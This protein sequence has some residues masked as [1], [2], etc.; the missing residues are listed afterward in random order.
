MTRYIK[1]F[2]ALFFILLMSQKSRAQYPL[3]SSPILETEDLM[4]KLYSSQL[5]ELCFL[6]GQ[7]YLQNLDENSPVH[8]KHEVMYYTVQSAIASNRRGMLEWVDVALSDASLPNHYYDRICF[9]MGE[10]YFDQQSYAKS[11]AYFT[12]SGIDN[13]SEEELLEKK[14][15]LGY[16]AFLQKNFD[17]ALV[18]FGSLKDLPSPYIY[19]ANYYY[20]LVNFGKGNYD[21]ALHSF[22]YIDNHPK[23]SNVIKYYVAEVYYYENRLRDC[24]DYAIDALNDDSTVYK[25]NLHALLAQSYFELEEYPR[26][27]KQFHEAE[28]AGYELSTTQVY[29]LAYAFYQ[30]NN[31]DS[32]IKNFKTLSEMQDSVG[33]NAMYLLADCYL[34]KNDIQSAKYAFNYCKDLPFNPTI[35]ENSHFNYIKSCFALGEYHEALRS[36]EK[37]DEMYPNTKYEKEKDQMAANIFLNTNNFEKGWELLAKD[38][39]SE[40]RLTQKLL[41]KLA[42]QNAK[43]N[44]NVNKNEYALKYLEYSN[45]HRVDNAVSIETD[46]WLGECYT[47]LGEYEKSTRYSKRY[48]MNSGSHS[49]G[50]P[51]RSIA[52]YNLAYNYLWMDKP[53]STI[54]WA[55]KNY[56]SKYVDAQMN[57]LSATRIAD[58][59][60]MK[61]DYVSAVNWYQKSEANNPNPAYI[62]FQKSKIAG[63]SHNASTQFELLKSLAEDPNNPYQHKSTFELA[64]AYYT[65]QKYSH[66][67]RWYDKSIS[68][69]YKA[70]TSLY[71]KG[72]C[73]EHL[74]NDQQALIAYGEVLDD[75]PQSDEASL[76]LSQAKQI[77]INNNQIEE[78]REFVQLHGQTGI[79]DSDLDSSSYLAGENLFLTEKYP[80]AIKSLK[81]YL[82][83]FPNGVFRANAAY[84][85]AESY[86]KEGDYESA[87]KTLK[88][89][90][91]PPSSAFYDNANFSLADIYR[92][93]DHDT[94]SAAVPLHAI[95]KNSSNVANRIIAGNL[96]LDDY[97]DM[98]DQ[99]QY[100]N[101]YTD[102]YTPDNTNNGIIPSRLVPIYNAKLLILQGNYKAGRNQLNGTIEAKESPYVDEAIYLESYSYLRNG[103]LA[104]AEKNLLEAIK[105]NYISDYWNLRYY[106]L[107]ADL[108]YMQNDL[109]NCRA[110]LKS[111]VDDSGDEEIIYR[112]QKKLDAL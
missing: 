63:L 28:A 47:R 19:D 62:T 66:A 21:E 49:R 33:Q 40:D 71:K 4:T 68:L 22:R 2:T 95:L 5:Y 84:Y 58:A 69:P 83:Q 52:R 93:K 48:V 32:A 44:L 103:K 1:L 101:V 25:P 79:D 92:K 27:V 100:L 9:S 104:D 14:F 7:S 13:L 73:Y 24:I 45:R 88:A 11:L 41:Q 56:L 65:D 31:L 85:L 90:E 23:Y 34:Q 16:I 17:E 87:K 42:L 54:Y 39:L 109:F 26:T 38:S 111:L 110:T 64:E 80:D 106:L 81:S 57:S 35:A 78:M 105:L 36:V 15:K 86:S 46:L 82:I 99:G 94:T 98:L 74:N 77:Y 96:L 91:V 61:N 67:I 3:D 89:M 29:T 20:G 10:Y 51:N 43:L 108:F 102:L 97:F 53:D 50:E 30:V 59:Y 107:L 37:F 112:A 70:S 72:L 60:F 18:Q 6:H 55:E 8:S 12:R 76:S 75:Y